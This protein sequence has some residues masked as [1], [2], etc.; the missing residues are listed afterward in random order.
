MFKALLLNCNS[1]I[2][3]IV[4]LLFGL[5]EILAN[6]AIMIYTALLSK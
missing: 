4:I 6:L 3:N 1:S 2:R 5:Y